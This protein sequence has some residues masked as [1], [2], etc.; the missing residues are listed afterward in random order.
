[1]GF[2][3]GHNCGRVVLVFNVF[4]GQGLV[5]DIALL[6][7]VV[8]IEFDGRRS[9]DRRRRGVWLRGRKI[10]E[11]SSIWRWGYT[12]DAVVGD[13]GGPVL[14]VDGVV[15]ESVTRMAHDFV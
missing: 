6:F 7:L 4:D 8:H 10:M 14:T 5:S 13:E 1:M 2:N 3:W 15:E 11:L 12:I 9:G